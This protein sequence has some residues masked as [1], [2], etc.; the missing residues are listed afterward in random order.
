V[1]GIFF[2]PNGRVTYSGDSLEG[3]VIA[4]N[5]FHVTNS[6]TAVTFKN[7]EEYDITDPDDY[8]F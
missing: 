1:T 5:G 3:V 7:I 6:R 8:P 2:A 4:R